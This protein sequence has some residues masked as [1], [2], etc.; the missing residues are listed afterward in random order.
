MWM[1][2]LVDTLLAGRG[3][4][5]AVNGLRI[6]RAAPLV[7]PTVGKLAGPSSCYRGRLSRGRVRSV[8]CCFTDRTAQTEP[9][10]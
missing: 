2:K 3:W 5:N 9:W 8:H 4:L 10:I 1:K 7:D 6:R